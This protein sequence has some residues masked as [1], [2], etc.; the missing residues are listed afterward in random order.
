MTRAAEIITVAAFSFL[1][2]W[3]FMIGMDREAARQQAATAADCT[4]YGAAMNNWARQ[5]NLQPPCEE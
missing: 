3:G 1:L 4:H 5:N 2:V